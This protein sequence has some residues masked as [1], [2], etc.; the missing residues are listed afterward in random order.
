MSQQLTRALTVPI[1]LVGAVDPQGPTQAV[2]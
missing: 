1:L 2:A